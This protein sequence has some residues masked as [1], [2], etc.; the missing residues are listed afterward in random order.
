MTHIDLFTGIGGFTLACQANGIETV[1][2]CESDKFCRDGLKEAWPG[3]PII[4][5]VRDF[6]GTKWTDAFIL[7]G[8]VPCQPASRAGKQ[9]GKEAQ[10]GRT[11]MRRTASV[12]STEK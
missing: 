7:T 6:D 11:R 2:M 1:V 9:R 10:R 5:D 3:I 4:E 8:G 12:L